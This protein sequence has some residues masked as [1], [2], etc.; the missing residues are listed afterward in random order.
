M[1]KGILI[2]VA[3]LLAGLVLA[4]CSS[5][6]SLEGIWVL[7]VNGQ[8]TVRMEITADTVTTYLRGLQLSRF[9]YRVEEPLLILIIDGIDVESHQY[10]L[11]GDTL[12]LEEMQ[13]QRVAS[14]S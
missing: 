9:D 4:A 7:E 3:A 14:G 13:F 6:G 2:F 1:K 8:E 5:S 12:T 11:E 10:R